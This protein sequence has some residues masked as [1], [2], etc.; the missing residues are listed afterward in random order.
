MALDFVAANSEYVDLGNPSDF[1][2]GLNPRSCS[3][4]IRTTTTSGSFA[5]A[6]VYGRAVTSQAFGIGRAGTTLFGVGISD[7]IT[8]AGF[9]TVN[10]WYH[11]ALTYDGITA[12]LYGDGV[13]VASGAKTWPLVREEAFIGRKV[14]QNIEHW[15]GQIDD[16]RVYDR[17]LSANEI[18]TIHAAQGHDGI[19]NG[20][21]ARYTLN[22]DAPGV[23]AS[24]AGVIKDVG[25]NKL[26]GTPV[27]TPTWAES[28]LNFRKRVG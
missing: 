5:F 11:V 14:T 2:D 6:F 17:V 22:E 4:W 13:E 27:N 1:P 12:R 8:S 16:V 25:P 21:A 7:D 23:A 18:K 9:F 15:A 24:G 19:V 26:N 10:Q 3:L 28:Q 20:L